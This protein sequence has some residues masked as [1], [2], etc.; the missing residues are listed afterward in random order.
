MVAH[1][2][3][4]SPLRGASTLP[5]PEVPGDR[6]RGT[7]SR[8]GATCEEYFPT[9]LTKHVNIGYEEN[10]RGVILYSIAQCRYI[11]TSPPPDSQ[12][13]M[14]LHVALPAGVT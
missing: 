2:I 6:K 11:L 13:Q 5:A 7:C 1:T 9:E 8:T 12:T 14:A 10:L 3:H 4:D